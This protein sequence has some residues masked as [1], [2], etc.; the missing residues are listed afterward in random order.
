M[1]TQTIA[2]SET[3]TPGERPVRSTKTQRHNEARTHTHTHTL[4]KRDERAQ[5][6]GKALSAERISSGRKCQVE[7]VEE[8]KH[9]RLGAFLKCSSHT[10]HTVTVDG[11]VHSLVQR[12][13]T[14]AGKTKHVPAP[15]P[16]IQDHSQS[17]SLCVIVCVCVCSNLVPQL[18][19]VRAQQAHTRTHIHTS[20][21]QNRSAKERNT[22]S[23]TDALEYRGCSQQQAVHKQNG[24]KLSPDKHI[25]ATGRRRN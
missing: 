21:D 25:L 23:R 13:F 7:D 20:C 1:D 3:I 11:A 16:Q 15:T 4:S 8:E 2:S 18:T 10:V 24:V 5:H 19:K 6:L 9:G 12:V 17:P 22:H 14:P